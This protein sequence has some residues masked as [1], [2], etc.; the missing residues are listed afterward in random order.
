M[1]QKCITQSIYK[2]A[3]T[4]PKGNKHQNLQPLPP[5]RQM[6]RPYAPHHTKR[7]KVYKKQMGQ[8]RVYIKN[9]KKNLKKRGWWWESHQ[10]HKNAVYTHTYIYISIQHIPP[11]TQERKDRKKQ[12]KYA[13]KHHAVAMLQ[14]KKTL[15]EK[16][17]EEEDMICVRIQSFRPGRS[18]T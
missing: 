3:S 9:R 18:W 5:H 6:H 17:I 8:K 16:K 12:R 7:T 10:T 2:K 1:I 11:K 15:R 4:Q 13:K 14:K